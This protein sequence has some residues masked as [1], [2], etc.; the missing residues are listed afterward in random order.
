MK[1][2]LIP[3]VVLEPRPLPDRAMP[4]FSFNIIGGRDFALGGLQLAT[5]WNDVE[6]VANGTQ[7]ALGANIARGEARLV[8]IALGANI[9]RGSMRGTQ[10]ALTNVARDVRGVQFS[11][12]N[13]ARDMAGLQVGLLNLARDADGAQLGIVNIGRTSEFSLGLVN[14]FYG[15]PLYVD[16]SVGHTG[17]ITAGLK[18]GSKYLRWSYLAGVDPFLTAPTWRLGVGLGAHVPISKLFLEADLIAMGVLAAGDPLYRVSQLVQLRVV[19]GWQFARR[20]ALYAGLDGKALVSA[21]TNHEELVPGIATRVTPDAQV[22]HVYL[23]PE[24]VIGARF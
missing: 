12:A 4:S 1:V 15:E 13:L 23:W 3:G 8:Q 24:F 11:L 2:S 9:T 17:A 14:V 16:A 5:L 10:I 20:F 6:T 21:L 7:L 18:H 19:A 22:A